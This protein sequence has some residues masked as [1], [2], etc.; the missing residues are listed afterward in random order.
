M[1]YFLLPAQANRTLSVAVTA[2][3]ESGIASEEKVQPVIGMWAAADPQGTAP[4][5]FTSAPFNQIVF[6]M[7][8][9]DAQVSTSTNFL[10]GISDVRGDGRPDYLY[11]AYV[12]YGN[13]VSPAR[14]SVDGG[15]VT[16]QGTGFYTGLTSAIGSTAATPLAVSAGQMI[17]AA[18]PKA[19]GP[20]NIT[21]S[22]PASGG[23]SVMTGVLTYGAAASDKLILLSGLNPSTPVGTQAAGPVSVRV[24]ASDGVTPVSGA[25]IGWTAGNGLQLSACGAV[26]SCSIVT[27]Q[28]GDAA[29][30]LTPTAVGVATITA[31]LAPG[32]YSPSQSVNATLYATETASDI[33]LLTPYFWIA[34]G[35][36]VSVPLTARVLSN[37]IAQN[38]VNVNFTVVN[39]SGVLSAA[40][41]ASS[42]SGYA[43]VTLALTQIAAFVQVVACVAPANA[44][45]QTFY[46]YPVP[47]AQQNLQPVSG[48]GQVSTGQAF[49]PVIVRVTDSSSP[50]NP[51]IAASVAF[52]TTVLRPG[53]TTLTGGTGETNP[54][55]SAMPVILQVSQSGGTSDLYG[56][57]SLVPSAGGFSAPVDVDVTIAAGTSAWIDDPLE[58][59]PAFVIGNDFGGTKL[60]STG[61]LPVGIRHPVEMD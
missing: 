1:A 26:S 52:Q 19:D 49:Q 38:N 35:A 56:L 15:A 32:V 4:P 54:S 53:G 34:Q 33:G 55:N 9:L 20:Q 7:T 47:L 18:P 39:G 3:D 24:L 2:L 50:P 30:W 14:V 13:S 22:D 60:P 21:I 42:S 12:L 25:T 61:P 31:T 57:A 16:V 46:A 41:A 51:V 58:V 37:G 11:H 48:A 43:T 28:S 27:D 36:T 8:R 45:C 6:G 29:T 44:P 23:S 5:A 17:L 10:I 40:S 59:L